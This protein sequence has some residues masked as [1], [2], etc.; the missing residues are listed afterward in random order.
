MLTSHLQ[1]LAAQWLAQG[2][3]A[4]LVQV[5]HT[6]G[7]VPREAGTRMLVAADAVAGTIGGGHLELQAIEQA[8]QR[9][10][11]AAQAHPL[12]QTAPSKPSTAADQHAAP[13]SALTAPSSPPTGLP[14]TTSAPWQ[15]RLAL[16]PSLGQCCGGVVTLAYQALD[17]ATLA[18][19]PAA[20]PL[21]HLQLHG[22]GHVGTATVAL[23][24]GIDCQVQW[25]DAREGI[26]AAATPPAPALPPHIQCLAGDDPVAEVAQA[27]AGSL[28]LVMTHRHDLDLAIVQALLARSDLPWVGLIGS[29]TKRAR[30]QQRLLQ[31]GLGPEALA[32][33]HCPVGLPGITGKA[34]AV[35]AVSVVAQL[36]ALANGMPRPPVDQAWASRPSAATSSTRTR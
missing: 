10:A 22:A 29:A 35:V 18:A 14:A 33:L 31:A 15:Q 7:S 12:A 24:A 27:P 32:R 34:P 16:G 6:Q 8:R 4:Q 11:Q 19:W 26:W 21:F 17:A 20:A 1:A 28:A 30:F 9:L 25:V 3:P 36:L 2:R 23:L 5:L 13:A